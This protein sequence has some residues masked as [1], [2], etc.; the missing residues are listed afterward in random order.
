MEAVKDNKTKKNFISRIIV[1]I[2]L[3]AIA[4]CASVVILPKMFKTDTT[5]LVGRE[6]NV[7]SSVRVDGNWE[8]FVDFESKDIAKFSSD[9]GK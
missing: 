2:V 9:V 8:T 3:V 4:I 1:M 7:R 6:L 5:E